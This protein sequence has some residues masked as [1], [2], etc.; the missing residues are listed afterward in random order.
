MS[1]KKVNIDQSSK[2]Q[3]YQTMSVSEKNIPGKNIDMTLTHLLHLNQFINESKI[4]ELKNYIQEEKISDPKEIGNIIKEL[5]KKYDPTNKNFYIMLDILLN[6]GWPINYEIEISE[7]DY[8]RL[9]N[10][11]NYEDDENDEMRLTLL[12]LAIILEDEEFVKTVLK[13]HDRNSINKP[14]NKGLTAIIYSILYNKDDKTNILELLLKKGSD[15]DRIYKI[16]IEPYK[17][18]QHSIFTLACS[19][20]LPNVIKYLIDNSKVYVNYA[21]T[22]TGDTGLHICARGGMENAL[23]ILLSCDRINPEI[24][25]VQN[26][27][28]QE[29]VADNEK[30]NEIIKLFVNYYNNQSMKKSDMN[31]NSSMQK[32]N[33]QSGYMNTLNENNLNNAQTNLNNINHEIINN[34]NKNKNYLNNNKIKMLNKSNNS[35]TNQPRSNVNIENFN[36]N[37]SS[38]FSGELPNTNLTGNNIYFNKIQHSPKLLNQ[39]IYNNLIS[40]PTNP[41]T[42]FNVEIPIVMENKNKVH[43]KS[44]NR[45]LSNFFTPK[46]NSIPILNLDMN[47]KTFQ[48]ELEIN[49]LNA[50]IS[51]I[52]KDSKKIEEEIRKDEEEINKKKNDLAKKGGKL[53]Q[54]N[55]DILNCN[56]EL[57][58]LKKTQEEILSQIPEGKVYKGSNKNGNKKL[59]KFSLNEIEDTEMFKILNK[60]LLDYQQ[61]KAEIIL[62]QNIV[63]QIENRINEI[64]TII[65][66]LAD[67]YEVHIYGS[68]ALGL[69]MDWSDID[70]ILVRNDNQENN[71][72][73]N[74]NNDEN[75]L[76]VQPNANEL[77]NDNISVANTDST[78]DTLLLNPNNNNANQINDSNILEYLSQAINHLNWVKNVKI[79]ENLDVKILRAECILINQNDSKRL[80]IDISVKTEKHFG[81]ECVD[82]INT[83]LKEYSVL[84]PI[85]IALRAI[86]HSANLHLPEKGGLSAYGLILMVVSYIQSQKENFTK[87]EPYLCG[88]IFYGF[89]RHYGIMFDFNKYLILTYTGNESNGYNNT[90]DKD[91]LN[92]NQYGQEFIILDPLNNKN[93]VASNSFQFMNL[94]MAFMIAYMVTKEDCDCGCHFGEAEFENSFQSTEHCYLKRML[95]SVRRFQG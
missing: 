50:Q 63:F 31:N 22:P 78:R 51:E 27:K 35:D 64:K 11:F 52:E 55:N 86:L 62:R 82:L 48:L 61:Y 70:L 88:K 42:V 58:N 26:Q 68:Y 44:G 71:D 40:E 3:L 20:N 29:V 90:T 93:N 13:Y 89:L 10:Y 39:N 47:D 5:L 41:N 95:N 60:D 57:E 66:N 74:N 18:E 9:F 94:K 67:N 14:D 15:I 12:S 87:N 30:K 49:S 33:N 81:L 69:N 34:S 21:I 19:Q 16:D 17:Y 24:Y 59:L 85:T 7:K 91:T 23:K 76:I 77:Q 56:Q 65:K 32:N 36:N 2:P 4:E 45:V 92:L 79:R 8:P 6:T 25:N 83:Y 43:Y 28:A 80:D 72:N 38:D 84:K 46:T 37:E 73:N 53:K 75:I 54:F 1:H